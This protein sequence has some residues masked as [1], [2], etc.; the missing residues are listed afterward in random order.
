M[1]YFFPDHPALARA[2]M[3]WACIC[4][5]VFLAGDFIAVVV[6]HRRSRRPLNRNVVLATLGAALIVG[7]IF[8]RLHDPSHAPAA[9][10]LSNWP[11]NIMLVLG[12]GA[13]IWT[14]RAKARLRRAQKRARRAPDT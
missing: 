8:V 7:S 14:E 6:L 9:A 10:R 4:T 12:V 13:L 11:A 2:I 3:L 1:D 5:L